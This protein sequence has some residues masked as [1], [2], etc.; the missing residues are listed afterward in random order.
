VPL[1]SYLENFK[2]ETKEIIDTIGMKVNSNC[3]TPEM[4]GAKG[5]G[6]ADDTAAIQNAINNSNNILF[7]NQKTYKT[8]KIIINTS[9]TTLDFNNSNIICTEDTFLECV[10]DFNNLLYTGEYVANTNYGITELNNY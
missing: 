2:N 3:V 9:N 8:G 4:F 6:E 7:G 5:D 1:S 10:N